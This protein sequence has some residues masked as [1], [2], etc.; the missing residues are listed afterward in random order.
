MKLLKLLVG[1]LLVGA[2]VLHLGTGAVVDGLRAVSGGAVA[3]ALGLAR[4]RP[5]VKAERLG[6]VDG[7][8]VVVGTHFFPAARFP[9]IAA[10]LAEDPSIT[11]ALA[12]GGVPDYRRKVTRVTARMPTPDTGLFDEPIRPAM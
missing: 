1:A 11:A 3:A 10:A 9:R 6:L 12:A 8:P 4:G 5:V 2:V 7:R